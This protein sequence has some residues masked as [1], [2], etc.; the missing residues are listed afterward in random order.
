MRSLLLV[1]LLTANV[2]AQA[3]PEQVVA[4][5]YGWLLKADM[6]AQ[7]RLPEVKDCLTPLLYSQLTRAYNLDSQSGEF[8]DFDPW[9]NSQMGAE[10]YKWGPARMV[11]QQAKVPITVFHP[12]A[13]KQTYTCVLERGGAGWQV[14]N[15]VYKDFNL[16][17]VLKE[18]NH[19]K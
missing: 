12:H 5:L 7:K 6:Q 19:D 15:L 10:D 11:G 8:L 13:G 2:W 1:L 4:R 16:L 17:S 3:T 9:S 14:A 18:L